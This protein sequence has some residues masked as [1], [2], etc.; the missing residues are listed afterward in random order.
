MRAEKQPIA[1]CVFFSRKVYHNSPKKSTET[2][3]LAQTEK[4]RF[5]RIR[6][7]ETLDFFA[8]LCYNIEV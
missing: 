2:G 1:A 3:H 5:S 6:T 4:R 8:V 7:R